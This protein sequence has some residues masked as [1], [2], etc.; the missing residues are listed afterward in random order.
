[1]SQHKTIVLDPPAGAAGSRSQRFRWLRRHRLERWGVVAVLV[2]LFV[3]LFGPLIAPYDPFALDFRLR[4]QPPSL[5]HFFGTDLSGRD[6][7]SRVLS[8]ARVTVGAALIVIAFGSIVGTA[9]G[10]AAA[11]GSRTV[12][13]V[14]MRFTDLGLSFPSLIVALGLAASLGAGMEAAIVATAL[15]WWP[16]YA[17]LAYSLVLETS[18]HDYVDNARAIGMSRARL[19]FRHILPNSMNGIFV[20]MTA[21]VSWV[22]LVISGL[23]FIGVGAQP[24]LAEWGAMIAQGRT[25]MLTAWWGVVFPGAA[26]ALTAISFNLVGDLLRTELDPS[27][28]I[29]EAR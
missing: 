14:L 27:V 5:E 11:L 2:L 29:T 16:G 20:Q 3:V 22:V 12:R 10:T 9:V 17:R 28:Q 6:I 23:S 19:I 26:I 25:N 1:V 13:E 4:L 15:T 18:A 21:D 24:P 8:G 7:F